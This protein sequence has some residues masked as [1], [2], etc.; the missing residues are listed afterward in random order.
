MNLK[1]YIG[2]FAGTLPRGVSVDTMKTSGIMLFFVEFHVIRTL[3]V[4]SPQKNCLC[5]SSTSPYPR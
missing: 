3:V 2:T 5:L 4:L 1:Y